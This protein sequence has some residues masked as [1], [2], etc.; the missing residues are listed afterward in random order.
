MVA[1]TRRPQ[2]ITFG[3]MRSSSVR[4]LLVYCQNYQCSHSTA[5]SA[6]RWPDG[7]RLSDIEPLFTCRLAASG[8]PMFGRILVRWPDAGQGNESRLTAHWSEDF[9]QVLRII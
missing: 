3:E 2:K 7:V 5:I 6:H 4:G 1:L 8:V 9:E